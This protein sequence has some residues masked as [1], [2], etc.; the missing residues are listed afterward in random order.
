MPKQGKTLVRSDTNA[1]IEAPEFL[2]ALFIVITQPEE[3][4]NKHL[5]N[6]SQDEIS[7]HQNLIT[8]PQEVGGHIKVDGMWLGENFLF[9]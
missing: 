6:V 5:K 1:S 7:F 2:A 4:S 8:R 9:K 3:T